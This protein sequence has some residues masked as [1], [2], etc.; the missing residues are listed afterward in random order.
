MD[1]ALLNAVFGAPPEKAIAYL[2]QKQVMPS[3]DWWQVQDNAHNKAFVVAHMAQL[4]LLEDVRQSLIEAQK[5]GWDLQRWRAEIEPKMKARGWW[6]KKEIVTEDGTRHVQL[7]SPYRLK[8]IYQTNMA[9]AYEAGRQ[10]AMWQDNT[11]YPYVMYSAVLDNRTRPH[12]RAL[13]GVVMRKDDPAWASIAPK[14]GYNCR[15]TVIEVSDSDVKAMGLQVRNSRD[16]H[17]RIDTVDV[18]N[19]GTAQ[20]ARLDFPDLPAFKTDAGWTG[21]P[22][23]NLVAKLLEKA[24]D[25]DPYVASRLVSK[26]LSHAEIRE[27]FNA[28]TRQWIKSVDPAKPQGRWQDVGVLPLIFIDVLNAKLKTMNL[29]PLQSAVISMQDK[30][31]ISHINAAHKNHDPEWF[32]NIAAHL[33]EQYDLYWDVNN[34]TAVLVF[35]IGDDEY[36]YKLALKLNWNVKKAFKGNWLRTIV[37][38]QLVNLERGGNYEALVVDGEIQWTTLMPKPKK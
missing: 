5:N 21:R 13:H 22:T 26:V 9:Q 36:R 31:T 2:Q 10:A 38:E 23:D 27:N 32:A 17:F 34:K 12:H 11:F 16:G 7:G 18:D 20:V 29:S 4:D 1:K 6:G 8:T 24:R 25:S 14:N 35:D 3:E 37:V 30:F 28:Q 15:C 19:G 33:C